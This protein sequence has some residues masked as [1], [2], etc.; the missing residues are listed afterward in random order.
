MPLLRPDFF[1]VS[2]MLVQQKYPYM[3]LFMHQFEW[4]VHLKETKLPLKV[5]GIGY[6]WHN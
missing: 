5:Y 6:I 2:L 4:Y 3:P 1:N